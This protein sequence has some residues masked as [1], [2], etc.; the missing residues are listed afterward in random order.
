MWN[1]TRRNRNIGTAKQGHGENNKLTIADPYLASKS[2][3]ERLGTYKK[4]ERTVNG[5]SFIFIVESTR[6]NCKHACTIT[7]VEKIIEN[8][9]SADY[10]ILKLIIFRQPKRKE[11]II[12][13]VWGRLIYS[14]EF[15]KDYFPAIIIEAI[16]Y[17]KKLTWEKS[18]PPD[19][20]KEFN[21]LKKDGHLFEENKK[22]FTAYF[23]LKNV[24]NTQLYRTV[25]HEFGHYVQ[26]CRCVESGAAENEDFED[27]NKRDKIY[28]N[29]PVTEKEKFAYQYAE[30]FIE[31]LQ[32]EELIPFD[33][34]QQNDDL[35]LEKQLAVR[36]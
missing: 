18:Q 5:H 27:W 17:S 10:G 16:D 36:K 35:F 4:L 7:D 28:Q 9:P 32:K 30:Q 15:E 20:Q 1:A 31:R 8:I 29:I 34:I 19:S 22:N 25:P 21:R 13:P 26:Y 6:K 2:F 3:F 14:Y 24:R 11:A 12:S 33:L 23:E